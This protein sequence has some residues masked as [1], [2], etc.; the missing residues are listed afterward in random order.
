MHNSVMSYEDLKRCF[1]F[2]YLKLCHLKVYLQFENAKVLIVGITFCLIKW[3]WS[4]CVEK[5]EIESKIFV[6]K[7]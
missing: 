3:F 1:N 4:I 7:F 5:R 6:L 2:K